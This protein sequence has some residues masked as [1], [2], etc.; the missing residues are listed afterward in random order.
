MKEDTGEDTLKINLDPPQTSGGGQIWDIIQNRRS[1][2]RFTGRPVSKAELSN[3]LWAA[4]GITA[5]RRNFS[6]RAAPSAGALYPMETYLVVNRAQGLEPGIYHYKIES[7]TLALLKKG[8]FRE[9]VTRAAYNQETVGAAGIVFIW[10]AVYEKSEWKYKERAYRYI[11]LEAGHI[12]QNL[13]LAAAA[14]GLGSCP[15]G[16]FN[17][18]EMNNLLGLD[19]SDES[20]I[21]TTALGSPGTPHF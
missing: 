3:L 14:L 8:D 1:V 17:D 2:R 11:C 5:K 9:A 16:A 13:A 6:F 15:V 7:H 18:G 19:G 4:Q 12:A 10:S 21:Y 20:V